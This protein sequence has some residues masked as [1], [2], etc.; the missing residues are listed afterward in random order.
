MIGEENGA[1]WSDCRRDLERKHDLLDADVG[2]FVAIV[3]VTVEE[4]STAP[5][6]W[7]S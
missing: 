3:S 4:T 1:D 2:H 7:V 6:R 5:D